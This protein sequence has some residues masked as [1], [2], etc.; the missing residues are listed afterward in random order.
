MK[1]HAA[2]IAIEDALLRF[3]I[4]LIGYRF[5]KDLFN[6]TPSKEK[7]KVRAPKRPDYYQNYPDDPAIRAKATASLASVAIFLGLAVASLAAIITANDHLREAVKG[8]WR[9]SVVGGV[10]VLALYFNVRQERVLSRADEEKKR[11]DY[12]L[13]WVLLLLN[14]VLLLIWPFV[15]RGNGQFLFCEELAPTKFAHSMA[16]AGLAMIVGS[17][18]FQVF[19]A[20]FYDS[21]AGCRGFSTEEGKTLRFHLAALASNSFLIGIGLAILGVMLLLSYINVWIAS[22]ASLGSLYAIV[23]LTEIERALWPRK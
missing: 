8:G 2:Q 23:G 5:K 7:R 10:V 16:L 15:C 11:W 3:Y 9:T 1:K 17:I 13:L 4:F 22:V 14:S 12:P 18:L 6:E 20:E 21:A 19:A